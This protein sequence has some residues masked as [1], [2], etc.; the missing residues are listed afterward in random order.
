MPYV[1]PL[2]DVADVLFKATYILGIKD[3]ILAPIRFECHN[4]LDQGVRFNSLV[5][6][7]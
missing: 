5:P 1:I 6:N 7:I 4:P 3:L 2:G